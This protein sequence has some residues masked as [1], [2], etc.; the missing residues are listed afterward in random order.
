MMDYVSD[1][2]KT[3]HTCLRSASRGTLVSATSPGE[4]ITYTP[5]PGF[6][7]DDWFY[8]H[9]Q[10]PAARNPTG[11]SLFAWCR[12][13]PPAPSPT[14]EPLKGLLLLDVQ[15]PANPQYVG[16]YDTAG[17]VQVWQFR[18]LAYVADT[19]YGLHV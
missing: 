18:A 3:R 12:P 19:Q 14:W 16:D 11:R 15:N 10:I 6:R 7:K 13:H 5:P 8:L 2:D 17:A 4:T 1:P 9:V